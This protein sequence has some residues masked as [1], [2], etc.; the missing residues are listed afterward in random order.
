MIFGSGSGAGPAEHPGGAASASEDHQQ[1]TSVPFSRGRK[2]TTRSVRIVSLQYS[3]AAT[4][5]KGPSGR[6]E[7]GADRM[8]T[9]QVSSSDSAAPPP[10]LA[11]LHP[12]SAPVHGPV[13]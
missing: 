9:T 8:A 1:R 5:A 6:R 3:D 7:P 12:S 4:I 13:L 2:P 11:L 10:S